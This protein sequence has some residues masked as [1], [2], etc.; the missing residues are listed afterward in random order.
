MSEPLERVRETAEEAAHDRDNTLA[1]TVAVMVSVLAA[2]LAI[3]EIGAKSSQN[4]YLT[5]HI[6]FSDNWAF[7]QSKNIRAVMREAEAEMLEALPHAD[8]VDME[9]KIKAA[10][11]YAARMRDDPKGGDGMKQLTAESKRLETERNAAF[12]A[13][14]GYE[15]TVGALQIA[16]VLASVSLVTRTRPLTIGAGVIG[17]VAAVF[18][19]GVAGHLF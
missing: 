6:A 15:Y 8:G 14:H 18:G 10:R 7:F 3:A 16:I 5:H 17:V 19:L 9:A 13:Y 1:R 11:E 2:A 4:E 12:H